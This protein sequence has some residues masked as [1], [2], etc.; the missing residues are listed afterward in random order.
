MLQISDEKKDIP[1]IDGLTSI[2]SSIKIGSRLNNDDLIKLDTVLKIM[3]Y[4]KYNGE[5]NK[6]TMIDLNNVSDY[7]LYFE[8]EGKKVYL[9][10]SSN[11]TEKM[12]I[13]M[14]IM[15]NEEGKKGEIFVREDL[16]NKNRTFF[17]EEKND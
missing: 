11:I 12:D 5:E 6:I 13:A 16:L 1:I 14:N 7:I 10:N 2:S 17:R 9:G 8:E 3:N 15:K 4:C